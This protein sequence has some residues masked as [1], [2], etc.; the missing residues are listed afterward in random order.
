M[1]FVYRQHSEAAR[2]SLHEFYR[3]PEWLW[4]AGDDCQRVNPSQK[5]PIILT[6]DPLALS[7]VGLVGARVTSKNASQPFRSSVHKTVN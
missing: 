2:K 1:S 5:E 7:R 4:I 3:D 6:P